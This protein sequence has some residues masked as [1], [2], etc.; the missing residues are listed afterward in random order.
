MFLVSSVLCFLCL[1]MHGGF[2]DGVFFTDYLRLVLIF[3]RVWIFIFSI[4]S[5]ELSVSGV[6]VLWSMLF[7]VVVRFFTFNFLVFYFSFEFVFVLM[8]FF[9]IGWGKT[10]ERL[11]ASFYIFFYTMVF[12]LPFLVILLDCVR[13]FS[14]RYLSFVGS[15]YSDFFWVFM[16]LVF[17]VKLPLFGF[18]L[19]LPKAHVEAPVAG[20]IILAGVLLK[21]GGYGV[22]R[23]LSLLDDFSLSNSYF[24][25]FVFYVAIYGGLYTSLLCVRQ[26]DLKI[27]IAYSSVVH[28]RVIFLG[29]V[30]F[31]SWG[32]YGAIIIMVAHGFVSPIMFYFMTKIY[33]VKHSRRIIVLK[34]ALVIS[35]VFC[36][37]WFLC[38]SLNLRVPPFM[39]F[40]SEVCI[41]GSL[42]FLGLVEW[43]LIGLCCF[44]TGVYC[45]YIYTTIRHGE[46]VRANPVAFDFKTYLIGLIHLFYVVFYPL[47]FF[48]L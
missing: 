12:S 48:C 13:T 32:L 21:L 47:V 30:S 25:N 43:R 45:I 14:R 38:C 46:S 8:F 1:Y 34:G 33:E 36:L 16:F 23:F 19:W 5:I 11:Q 6:S 27:I 17:I 20:S 31:T 29:I 7:F 2:Y 28:I 44:F 40:Y 39:S 3:V 26:I 15:S 9:L 18:H 4:L 41:I 24:L 10:A 37:F 22:I 35:P 42:G